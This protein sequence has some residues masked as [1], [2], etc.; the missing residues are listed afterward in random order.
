MP[1]DRVV[2]TGRRDLC[3]E[4]PQ[5]RIIR[6]AQPAPANIRLGPG[7][8]EDEARR[9][10]RATERSRQHLVDRD[11]QRAHRGA[12][13]AGLFA[14]ALREIALMRAILV[15]R[16]AGFVRI[17]FGRCMPE[18]DR[19]TA[20]TQRLQHLGR[21]VRPGFHSEPADGNRNGEQHGTN[22]ASEFHGRSPVTDISGRL[23]VHGLVVP[24]P[25]PGRRHLKT[26]APPTTESAADLLPAVAD[27]PNTQSASCPRAPHPGLS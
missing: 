26:L 11:F 14:A 1:D 23:P 3:N 2:R 13:A 5:A 9:L 10:H 7:A 27:R 6:L 20:G 25:A 15:R 21:R 22:G 16:S 18:I 8:A 12:D 17:G 4:S 24:K 19:V